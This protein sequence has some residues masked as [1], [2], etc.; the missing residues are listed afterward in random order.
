MENYGSKELKQLSSSRGKEI[1][2][3]KKYNQKYTYLPHQLRLF[4]CY[5]I[6]IDY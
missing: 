3:K 2:P 5:Y 1:I 4:T 6:N